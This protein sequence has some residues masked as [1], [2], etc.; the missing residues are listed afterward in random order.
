MEMTC[1]RVF[2]RKQ[3]RRWAVPVFQLSSGHNDLS[4]FDF[5]E[6]C[7]RRSAVNLPPYTY[8]RLTPLVSRMFAR[9][10]CAFE[11]VSETTVR[12]FLISRSTPYTL[13]TCDVHRDTNYMCTALCSGH[14]PER[15]GIV[16]GARK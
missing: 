6:T 1:L 10:L 15:D 7:N 2:E 11:D 5:I 12:H 13:M 9:D 4:T 16:Y 14:F 3:L 8:G